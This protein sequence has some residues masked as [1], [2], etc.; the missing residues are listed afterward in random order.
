MPPPLPEGDP[1]AG[2]HRG[3][4]HRSEGGKQAGTEGNSRHLRER[5]RERETSK[6]I[7]LLT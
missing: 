6:L 3:R 7:S 5:E 1:E 4:G 2:D